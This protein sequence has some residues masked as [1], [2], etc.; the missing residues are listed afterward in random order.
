MSSE[1]LIRDDS[2]YCFPSRD[3]S[4]FVEDLRLLISEHVEVPVRVFSAS[5]QVRQVWRETTIAGWLGFVISLDKWFLG[6]YNLS[7]SRVFSKEQS[8][9]SR[10]LVEGKFVVDPNEKYLIVDDDIASGS[11]IRFV[12]EYLGIEDAVTF[13]MASMVSD[14]IYD[15]VDVRDFVP[16]AKH[17]GLYVDNGTAIQRELYM[18][19]HVDLISRMKLKDTDSAIAFT[20][21]LKKLHTKHSL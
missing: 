17:G 9:L 10:F 14:S 21:S 16:G 8:V 19:P 11:T 7:V 5:D 18:H 15:I 13:S 3:I 20:E 6:D 1:Y 2:D 12:K 4:E